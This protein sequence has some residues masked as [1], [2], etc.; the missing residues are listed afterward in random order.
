MVLP[1]FKKTCHFCSVQYLGNQ[2][3]LHENNISHP[4]NSLPSDPYSPSSSRLRSATIHSTVTLRI[5]HPS[6][7]WPPYKIHFKVL[8]EPLLKF[9][10]GVKTSARHIF[11]PLINVLTPADVIISC[12]SEEMLVPTRCDNQLWQRGNACSNWVQTLL[13]L[14]KFSQ[15]IFFASF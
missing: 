14:A 15:T 2:F 1:C 8:D 6:R 12:D 5:G 11:P 9:P 10:C 3:F 4:N 7:T 13:M